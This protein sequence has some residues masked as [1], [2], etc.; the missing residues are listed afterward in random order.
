[1]LQRALHSGWLVL[2]CEGVEKKSEKRDRGRNEAGETGSDPCV[3][4]KKLCFP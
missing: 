3:I 2:V 1:M 4:S